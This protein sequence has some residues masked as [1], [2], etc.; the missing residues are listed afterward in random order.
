MNKTNPVSNDRMRQYKSR[1]Y[2][3][4]L[5]PS[6]S[7]RACH[8]YQVLHTPIPRYGDPILFHSA[9]AT[10]Q[11]HRPMSRTQHLVMLH[12][13]ILKCTPFTETML[14]RGKAST[15]SSYAKSAR[16]TSQADA[17]IQGDRVR[18]PEFFWSILTCATF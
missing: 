3:S 13:P 8:H 11:L 10:E 7:T 9:R 5:P 1:T 16:L 6:L 15:G 17:Y 2:I 12:S 18:V 4:P 14:W